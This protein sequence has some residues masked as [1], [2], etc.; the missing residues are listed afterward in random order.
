MITA[1]EFSYAWPSSSKDLRSAS[2]EREDISNRTRWPYTKTLRLRPR[3]F[4]KVL[5][6]ITASSRSTDRLHPACQYEPDDAEHR[7]RWLS[8][9]R[10]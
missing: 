8:L 6:L 1:F 2:S 4:T 9:G 10:P 3:T 5:K 7:G